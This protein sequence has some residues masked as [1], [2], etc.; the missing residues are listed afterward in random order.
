MRSALRCGN[1]AKTQNNKNNKKKHKYINTQKYIFYSEKFVAFMRQV[2][3]SSICMCI[4]SPTS[5]HICMYLY[6]QEIHIYTCMYVYVCMSTNMWGV[7]LF[8]GSTFNRQL[9]KLYAYQLLYICVCV[10]CAKWVQWLLEYHDRAGKTC[11]NK[12]V[13]SNNNLALKWQTFE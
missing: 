2:E 7:K 1:L 5:V 12:C 8:A 13:I 11:N 9:H 3:W 6:Q 10:W 4:I